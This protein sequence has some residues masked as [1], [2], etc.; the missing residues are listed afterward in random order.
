M[1]LWVCATP[2]GNLS[3]ASD[4]LKETLARVDLI[5][6]EDTRV[7]QKLCQAWKIEK[8][9]ISLQKYNEAQRVDKLLSVLK[10][11]QEIA[12]VSDAGTPNIAD[13]GAYVISKLREAGIRISPVPGPSSVTAFLSVAGILANQFYFAGF[14]PKKES[15]KKD[16]IEKATPDEPFVFFESGQRLKET[17]QWI[18]SHVGIQWI[19]LGKE[20]TKTYETLWV[21]DWETVHQALNQASLKGEWIGAILVNPPQQIPP[22]TIANEL[23]DLGLTPRQIVA[24]ATTYL[25]YSKNSIYDAV[26]HDD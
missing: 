3:D 6:A 2:I 15:E 9:M 24:V 5:A 16:R 22:K 18:H 19:A 21:G 10:S 20:L 12:L 4:R 11:G 7:T 25:H 14:F 26:H 1:T 23:K 8:P 13:P 17:L